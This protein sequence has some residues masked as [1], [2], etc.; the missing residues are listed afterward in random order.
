MEGNQ[1]IGEAEV[2]NTPAGKVLQELIKS[3]VKIGI[4]SRGTGTLTPI[5]GVTYIFSIDASGNLVFTPYEPG[6]PLV[7]DPNYIADVILS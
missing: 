5:V 1:V 3:G 2:L 6:W 7:G 4:S